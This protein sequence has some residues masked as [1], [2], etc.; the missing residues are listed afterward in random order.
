[1]RCPPRRVCG[2]TAR[3]RFTGW[4]SAVVP[5]LLRTRVSA[6]TSVV[7]TPAP[8]APS[9]STPVTVRQTPFTA[10]ESPS[11]TPSS[12]RWARIRSTA[13]RSPPGPPH[14]S[15]TTRVPTSSTMPVNT[16]TPSVRVLEPP[17]VPGGPQPDLHVPAHRDEIDDPEGQRT[18]DRADSQVPHEGGAGAQ[19][20]GCEV[21][22]RLVDQTGAQEGRGESRAALQQHP[23]DVS[24]EQLGQEPGRGAGAA[25]V[26][27]R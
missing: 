2:V 6:I 19:Q 21:H 24:V 1:M 14:S 5:R 7:Q 18:G 8:S 3:S 9:G 11:A 4:P 23:A 16:S 26:R 25:D 22:D 17:S 20:G 12:T 15:R 10:M 27:R 13:A